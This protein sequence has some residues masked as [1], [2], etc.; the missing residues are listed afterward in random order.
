MFKFGNRNAK[1]GIKAAQGADSRARREC[2]F[3]YV[4][5]AA[6]NLMLEHKLKKLTAENELLVK[7]LQ[8]CH[9]DMK[10]CK[11]GIWHKESGSDKA[12]VSGI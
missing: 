8:G 2:N 11:F 6:E 12:S 3:K 10:A 7:N 9:R 4:Q 1:N 5:L